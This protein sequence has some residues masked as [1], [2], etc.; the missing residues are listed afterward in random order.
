MAIVALSAPSRAQEPGTS[1]GGSAASTTQP[2][3]PGGFFQRLV[4][5]YRSDWFE[6]AP[7]GPEPAFRGYPAPVTSPPFPF[8][9][10]PYGGSSVIGQPDTNVPP[11][12]QTIYSGANGDAWKSSRIKVYGWVDGGFNL[13][14]SSETQKGKFAN[15]P[16][17]DYV[18]PNSFQLDQITLTLERIPDTVQTD[19]F[20]WGFRFTN[21]YGL[22]YRFTT[23]K[24][25]FSSQLIQDNHTYGYD[26]MTAYVDLYFPQFASGL[27]VRIGRYISLPDTEAQFALYTYTYSH[28]MTYAFDAYSQTGVLATAKLNDHWLAQMGISAGNDVAPWTP[29][30]KVTGTGCVAYT[31]EKGAENVYL[32]ANSVNSGQYAYNNLQAF[33]ALW[34]RKF[35]SSWHTGVE[36]WYMYER[37]VPSIFGTVPVEKNANGAYCPPGEQRCFAPEASIV[38]FLEKEVTKK[39]YISI[40]NE[41][42]DDMRGQ[43]TGYKTRYSEHL[44]GWG[45]WIGSTLLLRPEVRFDH[46]YDMPAYQN[47]TKKSQFVFAMDGILFF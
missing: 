31:W 12:M 9:V 28:S 24:G 42:F 22:D 39:N 33:Y 7:S 46:A 3:S 35:H 16:A 8:T 5:A 6:A 25:Y 38:N 23:A 2:A 44:L 29:D 45:H 43:R 17:A 37:N 36:T 18:I 19:H 4:D 30:A 40:R 27:N 41:F 34:Y 11:L 26:P 21:F 1:N 15:F 10:W 32:C 13:S 47:G 20:D 14:T